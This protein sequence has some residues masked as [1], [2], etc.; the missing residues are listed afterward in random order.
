ME[1]TC[2]EKD[3]IIKAVSLLSEKLVYFNSKQFF[4]FK[5]PLF[6]LTKNAKKARYDLLNNF[7]MTP[8]PLELTKSILANKTLLTPILRS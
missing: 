2:L 5:L 4:N 3:K 6:S 8:E 7:D 1:E